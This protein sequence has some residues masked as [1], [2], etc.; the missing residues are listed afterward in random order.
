MQIQI[1]TN[2]A[3][4]FE[5]HY[6]CTFNTVKYTSFSRGQR[7]GVWVR[8]WC[9]WS[10]E[11]KEMCVFVPY[12]RSL[13]LDAQTH[14]PVLCLTSSKCW[15]KKHLLP[16]A[17][18]VLVS[19]VSARF[20]RPES[21]AFSRSHPPVSPA[22]P[23]GSCRISETEKY[24]PS[25]T[26][27]ASTTPGMATPPRPAPLW[28]PPRRTP[29][30]PSA[31]TTTS[32]PAWRG[33]SRWATAMYPCSAA[34]GG[35]RASPPGWWPSIRRRARSWRCRRCAGVCV[36]TSRWISTSRWD[37]EP[38]CASPSRRSSRRCR[39]RTKP[40]H[41]MPWSNPTPTTL[42]CWCGARGRAS[43][44]WSSLPNTE[45]ITGRESLC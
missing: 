32:T 37:R 19:L 8:W 23:A 14:I 6:K 41:P 31:W 43:R 25:A 11:Q 30:S 4:R 5:V 29:S 28:V 44:W 2:I 16:L 10:L 27:T 38:G 21:L 1:C 3:L 40:S 42:R 35:T 24:K 39:G 26:R 33:V 15:N 12:Q 36:C 22:G 20:I 17:A 7:C 45:T 18:S 9:C 13:L 34:S